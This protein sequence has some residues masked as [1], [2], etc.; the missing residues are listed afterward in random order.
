M[1]VQESHF[2]KR[3]VYDVCEECGGLWLDNWQAWDTGRCKI[4]ARCRVGKDHWNKSDPRVCHVI[5]DQALNSGLV[6]G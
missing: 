2:F 1:S 5:S 4:I 3:I 6:M